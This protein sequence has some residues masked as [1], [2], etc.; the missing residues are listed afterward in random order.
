MKNR[1]LFFVFALTIP[2]VAQAQFS[3]KGYQG[4]TMKNPRRPD[5]RFR[6][7]GGAGSSF[8]VDTYFRWE[9]DHV[10]IQS[11][12]DGADGSR[13]VVQSLF[14]YPDFS[15][16]NSKVEKSPISSLGTDCFECVLASNGGATVPTYTLSKTFYS[17]EMQNQVTLTFAT[18]E[19]AESFLKQVA[20]KKRN[21]GTKKPVRISL[22][23]RK[24][25]RQ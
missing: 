9:K 23:P 14:Y 16:K 6:H 18:K 22:K 3:L 19:Q 4:R 8:S 1:F 15:P 10:R 25:G 24:M 13:Q 12:G 17:E 11:V 20:A 21:F 7:E 2:G 5:A